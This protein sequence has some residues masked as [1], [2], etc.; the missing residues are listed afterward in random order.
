MKVVVLI[1]CMF[2]K[3]A[4]IINRSNIQTDVVIINQCDKDSVE[5]L[6]FINK[7]GK[8]CHAKI[9]NT[10]ERGLSRSRNLALANAFNE[11]CIICDD[12]E[13]FPDNYE[14]IV[15]SVY[16]SD[17]ELSIASF[18]LNWDDKIYPKKKLKMTF[19][20]ILHTSSQQ[21]T[22]KREKVVDKHI[23]FD[24]KMGSGTGNGGGEENKFLLDCKKAGLKMMYFPDVLATINKGESQWF[25]GYTEKFFCNQGWSVKRLLGSALGY[26]YIWYYAMRHYKLYN[27]ETTFFSAIT[28]MHKGY[29]EHR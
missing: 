23:V 3:D 21:I 11:I 29:F 18:A 24:E 4:S 9:V 19:S 25:H 20:K 28:N 12:D 8:S 5:E 1:S 6:D 17:S 26:I 16:D 13:V 22:F 10:T 2:Q 14:D 27:K 15:I 7:K